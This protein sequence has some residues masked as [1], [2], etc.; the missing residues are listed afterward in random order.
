MATQAER[1]A[2]TSGA[3]RKAAQRL[4]AQHGFDQVA[5]D[6]IAAAA[7]VTRGAFY[8]HYDSKAE[9]FEAVF[10]HIESTVAESVRMA[11]AASADP[12]DQLQVGVRRYLEIASDRRYSRIVLVDAPQVL[13]AAR[14]QQIEEAY[15]VGQ[16]TRSISA[17]RP[18][19]P[20]A[21]HAL[22][23]RALLA[24]VCA[25]ALHTVGHRG[26]MAMAASVA[27]SLVRSMASLGR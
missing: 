16:V 19:R 21:E 14:Y 17:L 5:V 11:A 10:D 15:F 2:A 22:A 8:H 12:M 1:R 9:L 13:G 3:L 4:F 27:S 24:A 18:D 25:L 20:A 23:A 26:D 6:D 7:G